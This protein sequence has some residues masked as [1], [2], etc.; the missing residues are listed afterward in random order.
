M[1]YCTTWRALSAGPNSQARWPVGEVNQNNQRKSHTSAR[2][3]EC[4]GNSCPPLNFRWCGHS[5]LVIGAGML[6]IAGPTNSSILGARIL[7]PIFWARPC[8]SRFHFCG[9]LTALERKRTG[10]MGSNLAGKEC[11]AKA[12]KTCMLFA[13][14]DGSADHSDIELTP[15]VKTSTSGFRRI[16]LWELLLLINKVTTGPNSSFVRPSDKTSMDCLEASPCSLRRL[17]SRITVKRKIRSELTA[18]SIKPR[19]FMGCVR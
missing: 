13:P 4:T 15:L 17:S 6:V 18:T 16:T 7:T 5:D 12:G 10:W 11:A 2:H 9:A 3:R 19:N 8:S 14:S 1:Q